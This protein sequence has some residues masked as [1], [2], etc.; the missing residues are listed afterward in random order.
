MANT[1]GNTG[2]SP[3]EAVRAYNAIGKLGDA[4]WAKW[5]DL[6]NF[7]ID[8]TTIAQGKAGAT[9]GTTYA[10]HLQ[11]QLGQFTPIYQ[12]LSNN[13]TLTS[14]GK[15]MANLEAVDAFR[16]RTRQSD[17]ATEPPSHPQRLWAAYQASLTSTIDF[18]DEDEDADE[19]NGKPRK[20]HAKAGH[21]R[22]KEL[23][24]QIGA[25]HEEIARLK[26]MYEVTGD[27]DNDAGRIWRRLVDAVGHDRAV[28]L[29]SKLVE[30]LAATLR[31][32]TDRDDLQ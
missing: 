16:E 20:P 32:V 14:L 8:R 4:S 30:K 25:L 22:E 18:Q 23:L 19:E 28:G 13:G 1:N 7:I 2:M 21:N 5:V 31:R 10:H 24:A 9:R 15:C 12:K 17:G 11:R 6:G 27:P 3:G 29:G 26:E